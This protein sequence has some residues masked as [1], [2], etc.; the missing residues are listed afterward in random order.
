MENKISNR[1][2]GRI[3]VKIIAFI[4]LIVMGVV[5][6]ATLAVCFVKT[7]DSYISLSKEENTYHQ[8]IKE[9]AAQV[10]Y[11]II[12]THEGNLS[13]GKTHQDNNGTSKNMEYQIFEAGNKE[14]I[15]YT[16]KDEPTAGYTK[17]A[18]RSSELFD[19]ADK[20]IHIKTIDENNSKDK[21]DKVNLKNLII[22]T[23]TNDAMPYADQMG[24]KLKVVEVVNNYG[25]LIW[26]AFVGSL[27]I[28]IGTFGFLVYAAGRKY[29]YEG[30]H[31]GR[32][33][34][35]P[36]DL[37]LVILIILLT[38]IVGLTSYVSGFQNWQVLGAYFLGAFTVGASLTMGFIMNLAAGI[39]MKYWLKNSVCGRIFGLATKGAK[40]A[41]DATKSMGKPA[42]QSLKSQGDFGKAFAFILLAL[43]ID[44][45]LFVVGWNNGAVLLLFFALT[46]LIVIGIFKGLKAAYMLKDAG[47]NL[48]AGDL[49]H[50]V[51]IEEMRFGFREHGEN[52]N[53]IGQGMAVAVEE[54]LKSERLKTEL[55]TNVSHDIKTP[56]TSI[57]NYTDLIG[58]E[59][60]NNEK[61]KEYSEVLLRQ[62]NRLKKLIEDLIEASKASSGSMDVYLAPLNPTV[63]VEQT[64]GENQDAIID[65]DL[66]IIF[67]RLEG[68]KKISADGRLL[69]RVFDNLINNICKY[70]QE[71]SRVYIAIEEANGYVNISFK[72][73]SKA[74]LNVTPEEL[75]ERFIRGDQSRNTE[76]NGLGL[77]I[78]ESL[79]KLQG[80]ILE[81]E[82]DGDLFKATIKF[83]A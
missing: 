13:P 42:H 3:W 61:I 44:S 57:I 25:S 51:D 46:I 69:W 14:P 72:N 56:L 81:I 47:A 11:D 39:K 15:A 1:V 71:G 37:Q 77:S 35:F 65:A 55:I 21:G 20:T 43:G 19:D 53:S 75:M 58:K 59:E 16:V 66:E 34:K 63:L 60:C 31:Q 7:D 52:L 38:A 41:L 24:L 4:I 27:L 6:T 83:K 80:G 29:G 5:G 26:I 64:L 22:K 8:V 48:A 54:R 50:Q 36:L 62:S 33:A 82:I 9:E 17:L 78:A 10:M 28:G 73:V 67:K 23:Y 12:Y 70:S 76:G 18:Y 79:I 2:T 32:L 40:S 45:I 74:P 49:S 68:D 30:F